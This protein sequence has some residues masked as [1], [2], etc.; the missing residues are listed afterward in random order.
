MLS[1]KQVTNLN[2]ISSTCIFNFCVSLSMSEWRKPMSTF[3]L[4]FFFCFYL[5]VDSFF[6][7]RCD[8]QRWRKKQIIYKMKKLD[9][10]S[11][12]A[13]NKPSKM[14]SLCVNFFFFFRIF[15]YLQQS[16]ILFSFYFVFL[17]FCDIQYSSHELFHVCCH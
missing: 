1:S 13:N 12:T 15:L 11:I 17:I 6:A 3:N 7:I 4:F 16:K 9:S 10:I 5:H 14:N 2:I 8:L